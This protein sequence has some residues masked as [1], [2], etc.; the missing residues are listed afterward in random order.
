[1]FSL[2]LKEK[3]HIATEVYLVCTDG[4][5]DG[6]WDYYMPFFGAKTGTLSK[7]TSVITCVAWLYKHR[8]WL[9]SLLEYNLTVWRFKSFFCVFLQCI[10]SENHPSSDAESILYIVIQKKCGILYI[11]IQKHIFFQGS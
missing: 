9:G 10:E 1:M 3:V 6:R 8:K 11:V 4:Q 7:L 5:T 2:K